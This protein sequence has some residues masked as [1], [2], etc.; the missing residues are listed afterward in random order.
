MVF[1]SAGQG[2]LEERGAAWLFLRWAFDHYAADTILATATTRAL[3]ATTLTGMANLTAVTGGNFAEMVPRWL[4]ACYLDDGTDLPF[5]SSGFLRFKSWGLRSIWTDPRNQTTATPPGPFTGFPLVPLTVGG[6]FS[7]TGTL[8]QGSGR[9]FL[10]VQAA[11]APALD[12]QVL[13]GSG[14]AQLDSDL[15]ARFGIVRIH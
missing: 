6:S 15:Q 3:D 10:L 2:T 8:R 4:M 13:G 14:G 9:H 1:P 12:L 5:E 7:H 11:N